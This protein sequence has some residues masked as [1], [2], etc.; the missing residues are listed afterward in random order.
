MKAVF[1]LGHRVTT[2]L[3]LTNIPKYQSIF[4]GNGNSAQLCQNFGIS[5]VGGLNTPNPPRYTTDV[6]HNSTVN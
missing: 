6:L 1:L 5:G 3:Q 4:Y 2:Q